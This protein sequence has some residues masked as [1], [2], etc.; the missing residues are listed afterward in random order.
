MI[1]NSIMDVE[2]NSKGTVKMRDIRFFAG[3]G[4]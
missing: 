3:V 2:E 4:G 1:F